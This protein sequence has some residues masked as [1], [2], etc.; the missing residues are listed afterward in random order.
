MRRAYR[1]RLVAIAIALCVAAPVGFLFRR[2][3]LFTFTD[4]SDIPRPSI[5]VFNPL[6]NRAPEQ[7][8]EQMLNELR[9]GD[10]DAAMARVHGGG[11][12][13]IADKERRYRL[14][15]WKLVNRIDAADKVT[16]YY[17]TD[18]GVSGNLDSDAF[19]FLEQQKRGWLIRDYLP[20]Y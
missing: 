11:S 10:V 17:R 8:A 14:R 20:M 1:N 7:L 9:R 2:P 18:R 3:V 19:V 5:T 12:R 16:L 4:V 6:R 13:E 15:R